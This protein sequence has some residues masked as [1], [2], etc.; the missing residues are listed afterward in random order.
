MSIPGPLEEM[1]FAVGQTIVME[2]LDETVLAPETSVDADPASMHYS[3]GNK[4]MLSTLEKDASE[5]F[6]L[7]TVYSCVKELRSE[8]RKWSESVGASVSHEGGV[9]KCSRSDE[10]VGADKRKEKRRTMKNIPKENQRETKSSR[11]GCKFAIRYSTAR[12]GLPPNAP[13]EAVFIT[14]RSFYRHTHGCF[15]CQSQL[16]VEKR[17]AGH[18]ETGIKQEQLRSIIAVLKPGLPVTCQVLREMMRPLYPESVAIDAQ[19]VCNMRWKIKRILER[20]EK[21]DE[22]PG[23]SSSDEK[24]LLRMDDRLVALDSLPAEH[25]PISAQWARDLLK[26]VLNDGNDA[27]VIELYLTK[28]REKDPSFTFRIA[29]ADD[30]SVNGYIWQTFQMRLDW[31]DFGHTIFL[32]AMKRQLNSI[33]WPYFGPCVF[34]AFKKVRVVAE[35]ICVQERIVTYAWYVF[36]SF[37]LFLLAVKEWYQI[38]NTDTQSFVSIAFT[39]SCVC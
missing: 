1:E 9:L 22:A 32:D 27:E 31:E 6:P 11:C 19:D 10:P 33:H 28:L 18:Y 17:K 26:T 8:V 14:D 5:R 37:H 39:G 16:I 38:L 30:G 4:K 35:S 24:D 2:E 15:P 3:E 36:V 25:V 7:N 12:K 23:L 13:K 21:D 34:D 29:K 20:K